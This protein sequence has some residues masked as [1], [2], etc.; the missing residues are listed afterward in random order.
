[1]TPDPKI[2]LGANALAL[3]AAAPATVGENPRRDDVAMG[4]SARSRGAMHTAIAR[5]A[6]IAVAAPRTENARQ[7]AP[8][9]ASRNGFHGAGVGPVEN[10]HGPCSRKIPTLN[11]HASRRW[12]GEER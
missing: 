6:S 4:E 10:G 5:R 1:M 7:H 2:A 8:F 3:A 11:L 9:A 12:K